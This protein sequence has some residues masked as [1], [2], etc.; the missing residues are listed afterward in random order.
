MNGKGSHKA[1]LYYFATL[2]E[3]EKKLLDILKSGDSILLKASHGMH[4]EKLVEMLQ[5]I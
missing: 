1:E 4:F 3:A 2:Q 5:D